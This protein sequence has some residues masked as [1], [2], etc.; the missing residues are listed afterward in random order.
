MADKG[1]VI[2]IKNTPEVEYQVLD[3]NIKPKKSL[4]KRA[5]M[6]IALA[7]KALTFVQGL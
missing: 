4:L 3:T 5:I 7:Y 6:A 2:I 1:F